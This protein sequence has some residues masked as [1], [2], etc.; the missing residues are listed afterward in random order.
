MNYKLYFKN[1]VPIVR[2]KMVRLFNEHKVFVVG[3]GSLLYANG[4]YG[5]YMK[6]VVK[7][8]HLRECVV[9]GYER[10]P[11]GA[12]DRVHFYGAIPEPNKH[13]NGALVRLWDL[14]DWASLMETEVI[15]GMFDKYNYRVVDITEQISGV[16]LPKNAVVHMVANEPKNRS[17]PD[18]NGA[19]PYYY[20]RVWKGINKERSPKFIEEFLTT[21]GCAPKDFVKFK[22]VKHY[23]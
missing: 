6:H 12:V 22:Q 17:I 16:K 18:T 4:W 2:D 9:N 19:Y 21:G 1:E 14:E 10:G 13:L 20:E 11:F 5:R 7:P 3:Y 8:K 23:Y 15:A